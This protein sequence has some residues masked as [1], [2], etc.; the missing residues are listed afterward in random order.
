MVH[1]RFSEPVD[2]E[3]DEDPPAVPAPGAAA[4]SS[5][6]SLRI[7]TCCSMQSA[8]SA[9]VFRVDINREC[10]AVI[11]SNSDNVIKAFSMSS[12][13]MT[14]VC[15]LTGHGGRISHVAFTDGQSM[16]HS[17]SVDGTIRG[18]DLRSRGQAES[19]SM[20]Q[21]LHS[22]SCAEHLLAVGG[23][24]E[25]FFWDRRSPAKPVLSFPDTHMEDVTQVR[26]SRV[27]RFTLHRM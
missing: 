18:W 17:S 16:L 22:F 27:I 12:S 15:D 11:A 5:S 20:R 4:H 7:P 14:P 2:D 3:M 10:S 21:E 6:A 1:I 25:V 23:Q 24:G 26:V 19:F 8:G 9:Y 13:Q